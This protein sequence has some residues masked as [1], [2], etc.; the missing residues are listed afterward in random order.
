MA[1]DRRGDTR[2][3]SIVFDD[4]EQAISGASIKVIGIGGGGGNAIN[5]MIEAGIQG[6]QFLVANTDLQSLKASQASVKLQIGEKLTR[7]LGVGGDP[8]KGRQSA[9]EDTEKIIEALEG[10]DMVFI[11]AG[12]GRG[13]GPGARATIAPLAPGLGAGRVAMLAKPFQ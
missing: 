11:T 10:A 3:G 4:S 13:T 12:P 7:G 9:L 1:V 2:T 5:R 8:E 6:V